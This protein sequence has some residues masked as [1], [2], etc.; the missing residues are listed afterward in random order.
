MGVAGDAQPTHAA[1]LPRGGSL[2]EEPVELP[3]L[4][5]R[6]AADAASALVFA[7]AAFSPAVPCAVV[8]AVTASSALFLAAASDFLGRRTA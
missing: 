6:A 7:S 4:D 8:A 3:V 2:A 1:P 5:L